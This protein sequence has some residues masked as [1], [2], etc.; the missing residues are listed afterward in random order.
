MTLILF[1]AE[2]N[3]HV[4]LHICLLIELAIASQETA[5]KRFLFC[6]DSQMIEKIV[7]K[8]KN[9]VTTLVNAAK[10]SYYCSIRLETPELKYIE[11]SCLRRIFRMDSA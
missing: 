8:S 7:P 11:L 3:I 4:F 2:M 9:F 6:M 10:Q 1:I 5:F